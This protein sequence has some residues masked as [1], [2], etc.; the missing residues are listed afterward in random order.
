MIVPSHIRITGPLKSYVGD[1]WSALL[2][3]GYTPLSSGSLLRLMARLSDWLAGIGLQA[4]E[5][6]NGRIEEFLEQRRRRGYTQYLSRRGLEPI[7]QHLQTAGVIS[8][9]EPSEV[10]ASELE[11]LLSDYGEY[12]LHERA[13]V[14][15]T[16]RRYQ[17]L[18]QSFL[19]DC[20]KSGSLE[21]SRLNAA[22]VASFVTHQARTSSVA[23]AKEKVTALRCVVRFLYLRGELVTDLVGA[24]P[25]VANWRQASLP[26]ALPHK[27]VQQLLK[28]C[29][30]RTH[31]GRRDFAILLLLVRLGLRS[32]EVAALELDD[33]HWTL[34][35]IVV[36]GKR[37]RED[38]LPLPCDVGDAIV[39]YLRRVRPQT[40][41]RT[42]FL[43][44]RAPLQGLSASAVRHI[45][46]RAWM[47][48]GLPPTGSH[49]LRHTVATEMLREGASLSEIA[50]VLRHRYEDTTAI[51]AKVDRR[52]LRELA[53]PW[54][55]G[56][57]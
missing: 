29:D 21:L 57:A 10:A 35:E 30:R 46:R 44:S 48:A 41:C 52:R 20:F 26:K 38:R 11:R 18:A 55:G 43:T 9:S 23:Y 3:R 14:P 27:Q 8:L 53:Q 2:A 4:Q 49:R 25:G 15:K 54:P 34:G 36:R 22:D 16:V 31:W 51:Y 40:S 24:V 7:L 50:Q 33:I 1:V 32:C 19:G 6:T 12:L 45:V 17:R 13:M 42:L 56:A 37:L 39:A 28:S 47:R 5:L